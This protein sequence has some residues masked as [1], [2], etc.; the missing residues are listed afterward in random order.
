MTGDLPASA[1]WLVGCQVPAAGPCASLI[2][3][4]GETWAGRGGAVL[5]P[6]A[7]R[8]SALAGRP[9]S[10]G[11]ACAASSGL[12]GVGDMA[13]DVHAVSLAGPAGGSPELAPD[14]NTV[15]LRPP[16]LPGPHTAD[17]VGVARWW[18]W[19]AEHF[20]FMPAASGAGRCARRVAGHRRGSP[21]WATRRALLPR[22]PPGLRWPLG[23]AASG[24][25]RPGNGHPVMSPGRVARPAAG[26]QQ[27]GQDG[28]TATWPVPRMQDAA[29]QDRVD[30]GRGDGAGRLRRDSLARAQPQ[31]PGQ[32]R[33]VQ[34]AAS[35]ARCPPAVPCF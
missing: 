10:T 11:L 13:R 26:W 22:G 34:M 15:I 19:P 12:R 32:P 9:H 7:Q 24:S 25:R 17:T 4:A 18:P 29:S 27:C 3:A 21:L 33:P 30:P 23:P 6:E 31:G 5:P 28:P 2:F 35:R 20:I 8:G 14:V 16:A 1:S